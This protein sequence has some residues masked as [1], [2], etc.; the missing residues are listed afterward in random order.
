MTEEPFPDARHLFP[1]I[2]GKMFGRSIRWAN[3]MG[4]LNE[5]TEQIR[6]RERE[7]VVTAT[8]VQFDPKRCAQV[9][10]RLYRGTFP[11]TGRTIDFVGLSKLIDME[12]GLLEVVLT[13]NT[14][15]LDLLKIVEETY[16]CAFTRAAPPFSD[17]T[18]QPPQATKPRTDF[19]CMWWPIEGGTTPDVTG[20]EALSYNF[21]GLVDCL[22][23]VLQTFQGAIYVHCMNGTDR[24][25]AVV[26]GY[27]M[28]YMGMSLEQAYAF[29]GSVKGAGY[30]SKPYRD[31]ITWYAETLGCVSRG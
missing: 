3:S 13:D 6:R 4:C 12:H 31:L 23:H 21:V 10:G 24:T 26:A 29:S 27:A 8:M 14:G 16:E 30:M 25:G 17:P 15:E 9:K 5:V 22:H 2:T 11:V 28:K 1:L 7:V 18:W 19:S 20:P